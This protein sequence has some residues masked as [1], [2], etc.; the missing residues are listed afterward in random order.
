MLTVIKKIPAWITCGAL[1]GPHYDI[2]AAQ[3]GIWGTAEGAQVERVYAHAEK[4]PN[5]VEHTYSFV[6]ILTACTVSFAHDVNDIGNSVDPWAVICSAWHTG[7]AA[8]AKAP[9]PIW[10]L[11]V[12]S[13]IISTGLITYGYNTMKGKQA[14]CSPSIS[15]FA[16][17]VL[18]VMGNKIT[19]HSP[20][21]GWSMEMGAA[22]TVLLFSQYSL[23]SPPPRGP[24]LALVSATVL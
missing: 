8:A 7:N 21:R 10:Q 22:I 2:H 24:L 17:F 6:Q 14:H 3:T 5:E 1:Y 13:V 9:V 23:P 19:Y 15:I 12:L 4:Y 20:I 16:N 18:A 11:A